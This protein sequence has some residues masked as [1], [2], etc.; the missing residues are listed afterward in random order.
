MTASAESTNW[1]VTIDG[2]TWV[3]DAANT[4]QV[5]EDVELAMTKGTV[6]RLSLQ[7]KDNGSATVFFNGKL[8]KSVVVDNVGGPKPTEI[9]G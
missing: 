2:Y 8:V 4:A 1:Y 7:T 6:A 9:A 3:V 5:L